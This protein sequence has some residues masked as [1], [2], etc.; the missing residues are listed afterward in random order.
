MQNQPQGSSAY[1]ISIRS[2]L[3][4]PGEQRTIS[5]TLDADTTALYGVTCIEQ[6]QITGE[7]VNEAG[8]LYLTYTVTCTPDLVCDRC[9]SPVRIAMENAFS[10]VVVT[11]I[12]SEQNDSEFL[13]ASDAVLDLAEVVMTDFRL[14]LP[15]KIL[16]RSD[17]RG[18]CPVCG[19]DRNTGECRCDSDDV[20]VCFQS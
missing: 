16:C 15:T 4:R 18:L 1:A 11:Q 7:L 10:H 5:V 20:T 6:P 19:Q 14:S 8:V 3:Y 9:L 12:A 13:L 17:C 2:L